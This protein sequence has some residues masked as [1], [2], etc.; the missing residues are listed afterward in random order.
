M[1]VVIVCFLGQPEPS[2]LKVLLMSEGV[3]NKL[4][5]Q[6]SAIANI[7]GFVDEFSREAR[8]SGIVY[9]HRYGYGSGS[10]ALTCICRVPLFSP[11]R[12]AKSRTT[13]IS[14]LWQRKLTGM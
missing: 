8:R 9:T 13:G 4:Y 6:L 2:F 10:L 11:V 1:E 14:I 3:N 7:I 5:K 12:S